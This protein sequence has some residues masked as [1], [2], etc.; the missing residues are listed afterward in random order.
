MQRACPALMSGVIEYRPAN[1][2]A[3]PAAMLAGIGSETAPDTR[4]A[5]TP[6]PVHTRRYAATTATLA[7]AHALER[8]ATETMNGSADGSIIAAVIGLHMRTKD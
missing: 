8:R 2:S 4:Y 6:N 3:T 7:G 5:P 1:A